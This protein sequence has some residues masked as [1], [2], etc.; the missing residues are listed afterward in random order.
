MH[1]TIITDYY[2]VKPVEENHSPDWAK[3]L[4]IEGFYSAIVLRRTGH[5][6]LP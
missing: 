6:R 3:N 5:E 1:K 2:T 4:P